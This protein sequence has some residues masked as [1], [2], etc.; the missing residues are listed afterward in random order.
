[1]F[2]CVHVGDAPCGQV[3][4]TLEK[5]STCRILERKEELVFFFLL[6]WCAAPTSECICNPGGGGHTYNKF[7]STYIS[8]HSACHIIMALA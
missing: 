3:K 6:Q 7:L 4:K 1:M 5:T 2:D 8:Q